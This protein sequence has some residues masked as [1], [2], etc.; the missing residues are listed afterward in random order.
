MIAPR[1]E[2]RKPKPQDQRVVQTTKQ[3]P[4]PQNKTHAVQRQIANIKQHAGPNENSNDTTRNRCTS[5]PKI[6][7]LL[8][9][10]AAEKAKSIR[11]T[12]R[13]R[14]AKRKENPKPQ[15]QRCPNR[16]ARAKTAEQNASGPK[17]NCQRQTARRS[18]RR[19]KRYDEA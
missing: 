10:F 1:S 18:K 2:N 19:V 17:A 7:N 11:C 16:K 13:E 6:K 3:K 5:K 15:D 12:T 4:K 8:L 14:R 9:K